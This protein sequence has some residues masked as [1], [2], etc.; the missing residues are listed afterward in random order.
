MACCGSEATGVENLDMM[1]AKGIIA[2]KKPRA[3]LLMWPFFK[4]ELMR[5]Q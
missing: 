2:T 1:E 4:E 5:R 3:G